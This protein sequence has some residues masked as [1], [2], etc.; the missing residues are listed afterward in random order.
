M[1]RAQPEDN[2]ALKKKIAKMKRRPRWSPLLWLG[3]ILSIPVCA[4]LAW[5][6]QHA[7]QIV[8]QTQRD[9]VKRQHQEQVRLTQAIESAHSQ[10]AEL[11]ERNTVEGEKYD[12]ILSDT[13][14]IEKE[15]M[16]LHKKKQVMR[17]KAVELRHTVKT[18]AAEIAALDQSVITELRE[19]DRIRQRRRALEKSTAYETTTPTNNP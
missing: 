15:I 10:R 4:W 11:V 3:W 9:V 2:D 18:L 7:N 12:T 17:D 1:S 19:V 16:A 5:Q 8:E 14:R 6:W 13:Q